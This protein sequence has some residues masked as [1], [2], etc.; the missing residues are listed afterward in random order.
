MNAAKRIVVWG[1]LVTAV[2]LLASCPANSLLS[3]LE[4][5]VNETKLS[6]TV[7]TPVFSPASGYLPI[8]NQTITLLD[9]TAGATI[10]YTTDGSTPSTESTQYSAP[11]T[12]NGTNGATLSI[13]AIAVLS[14][15]NP[16][17]VA[18]ATYTFSASLVTLFVSVSPS[19]SDGTV[20]GH[21][22]YPAT[23]F[24]NSG[25]P[26]A[27][28]AIPSPTWG[29]VNWTV[30]AGSATF[31]NA[32][33]ANTTVTLTST[34]AILATFAQY[35]LTVN[36]GGNGTTTPSGTSMA[37]HGI[38]TAISATPASGYHF[39]SWTVPTGSVIFGSTGNGTS[40]SSSDTVTLKSGNTTVQAN[41][42]VSANNANLSSAVLVDSLSTTYSFVPAFSPTTY[43]Y[44]GVS[45]LTP[46]AGNP[47]FT[48]TLTTANPSAT[49][50]SVQETD[51]FGTVSDSHV[52][53]V[54]TLSLRSF[55]VT[56]TI[57]VTAQD[58]TTTQTDTMDVLAYWHS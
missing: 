45:P 6:G 36:S 18:I 46:G 48:L 58:G 23:E 24:V 1:A 51:A 19:S 22:T 28:S 32:S 7:L 10:Y 14:T 43:A 35:S 47:T 5:K 31:G 57:L 37:G 40:T 11:F 54:Y 16:S 29:F 17:T 34:S 25:T 42:A 53:S 15:M 4:Q 52:G 41:F 27:L 26:F 12:V 2:T 33:A 50:T 8:G 49:I 38:A 9:S 30:T 56:I 39:V 13:K 55:I 44:T 20:N 3:N 21:S